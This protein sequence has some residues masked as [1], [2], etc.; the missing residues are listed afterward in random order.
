MCRYSIEERGINKHPHYTFL[1]M[2]FDKTVEVTA[3][4][5]TIDN[6]TLLTRLGGATGVGKELAWFIL[7]LVDFFLFCKNSN[8]SKTCN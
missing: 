2:Y 8:L 4:Q 1:N 5:K 7:I 6:L 3:S